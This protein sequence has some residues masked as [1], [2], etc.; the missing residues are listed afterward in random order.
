M[1]SIAPGTVM[2]ISRTEMPP[3][4]MASAA[5]IAS[6]G[7]GAMCGAAF[8]RPLRAMAGEESVD[9]AGSERVPAA[10]PIIDLE[11]L[12]RRG[13]VELAVHVNHRSP[14]VVGRGGG[15]PKGRGHDRD[16]KLARDF[17]GHGLE[18]LRVQM[19][20][21]LEAERGREVLLIADHYVHQRR[22][23]PIHGLRPRVSADGLP[24]GRAIVEVVGNDDAV[25]LGGP[26]GFENHLH[27]G[28]GKTGED[29]A[30]VEPPGAL[31]ED[32]VPIHVFWVELRGCGVGA[33]G[34]AQSGANS[35]TALGEIQSVA[36]GSSNAVVLYPPNQRLIDAA[37]IH[38]ILNQPADGVVGK[39]GDD[40]GL[41]PE[42]ALEAARDVVFTAALVNLKMARGGDAAVA[43]V[44]AQHH[45]SQRDEVPTPPFL[46]GN[47]HSLLGREGG[48]NVQHAVAAIFL[49]PVRGHRPDVAD[50]MA[51]DGDIGMV[52]AG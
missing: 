10:H 6:S 27:R 38:Q 2:V 5:R 24:Q 19:A 39:S 35:K 51:G 28:G 48:L 11:I 7:D 41:H 42:A 22:D 18:A 30:G 43:G 12:P 36:H 44:K 1:T 14:V 47:L 33:I 32:R 17:G 3:A 23:A 9:E 34:A 46:W 52:A 20:A 40:R 49:F 8:D 45:L 50:S 4:Q 25:T 13:L 15:E 29:S 16:G 26:D 31:A 37:L 21:A